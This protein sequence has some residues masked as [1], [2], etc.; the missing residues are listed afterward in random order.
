MSEQLVAELIAELI[1]ALIGGDSAS[2]ANRRSSYCA[3]LRATSR[4]ALRHCG[5]MMFDAKP[6][7]RASLAAC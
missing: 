2:S 6:A 4:V 1:A 3:L 5:D 7:R